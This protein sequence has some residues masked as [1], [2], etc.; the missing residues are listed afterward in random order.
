MYTKP[1]MVTKEISK[2]EARALLVEARPSK[3]KS[4]VEVDAYQ[5][6]NGMLYRVFTLSVPHDFNGDEAGLLEFARN[7]IPD[8]IN[9]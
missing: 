8:E 9:F 7:N 2:D 1:V 6:I 4:G 5:N 3:G